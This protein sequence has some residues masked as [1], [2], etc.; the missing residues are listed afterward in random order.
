MEGHLYRPEGSDG[1]YVVVRC[2]IKGQQVQPRVQRLD[3]L[4]DAL[5]DTHTHNSLP[6]RIVLERLTRARDASLRRQSF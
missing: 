3:D 5:R 2:L 6:L 4:N 1:G